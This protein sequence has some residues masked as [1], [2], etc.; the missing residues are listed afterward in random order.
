M[1]VVFNEIGHSSFARSLLKKYIYWCPHSNNV[2]SSSS[3]SATVTEIIDV[4]SNA[5]HN[6]SGAS[7]SASHFS[8]MFSL[9]SGYSPS[10]AI[11][12]SH[13]HVAT[14]TILINTTTSL[15]MRLEGKG[16]YRRRPLGWSRFQE[17]MSKKQKLLQKC[18]LDSNNIE[19]MS[20]VN[21][22]DM[23][24]ISSAIESESSSCIRPVTLTCYFASTYSLFSHCSN[25]SRPNPPATTSYSDYLS[26]SFH[27]AV[28]SVT[29]EGYLACSSASRN[30][31]TGQPRVI[32]DPCKAQWQVSA[33]CIQHRQIRSVV[34]I[35]LFNI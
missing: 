27:E 18:M 15:S 28:A 30:R 9:S 33:L 7:A 24:T 5:D 26:N 22:V 21:L 12:T 25:Q 6:E 1:S 14:N 29:S 34:T 32:Y 2:K 4:D 16:S 23:V 31:H 11:A 20:S 13:N 3:L 17:F 35:T 8:D 10:P 19:F